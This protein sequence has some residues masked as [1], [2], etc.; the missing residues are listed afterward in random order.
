VEYIEEGKQTARLAIY[1]E[2]FCF[3]NRVSTFIFAQQQT[4]VSPR[5]EGHTTIFLVQSH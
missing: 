2:W 4:N 5:R 1:F 3:S